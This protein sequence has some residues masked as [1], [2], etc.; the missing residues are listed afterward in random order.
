MLFSCVGNFLCVCL[1]AWRFFF[2]YSR[3]QN[4]LLATFPYDSS[5]IMSGW[6]LWLFYLKTQLFDFEKF[7]PII[8]LFSAVSIL[9]LLPLCFQFINIYLSELF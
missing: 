5:L 2:C 9:L 4:F 8:L 3:I 6:Y 7:S 1:N